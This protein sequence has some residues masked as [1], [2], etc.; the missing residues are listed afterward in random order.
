LYK[1]L[2]QFGKVLCAAH[3]APGNPATAIIYFHPKRLFYRAPLVAQVIHRR[4]FATRSTAIASA[5][6][7]PTFERVVS[8]ERRENGHAEA[9]TE[10][11]DVSLIAFAPLFRA[12]MSNAR[13]TQLPNLHKKRTCCMRAP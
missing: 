1:R 9:K 4:I 11:D 13:G 10:G 7:S 12:S 5:A 6:F 3:K 8:R 2:G